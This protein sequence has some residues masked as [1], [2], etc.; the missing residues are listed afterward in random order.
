M[1]KRSEIYKCEKC[2]QIIEVL[3][4]GAHPVCCGEKMKLMEEITTD[5]PTEKHVPV[6]EAVDGGYR[7]YVGVTEH[8]MAENHYIEWIEL[9]TENKVYRKYLKPGEKPE[10][11]FK[12]DEKIVMARSY[13]NIHG[14]WKKEM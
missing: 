6:V 1:T 2:G 8:P 12:T 3:D 9:F 5:S 4:G 14:N 11:I 10:A 7:V 13:C